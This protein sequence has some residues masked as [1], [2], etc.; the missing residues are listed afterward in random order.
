MK[1]CPK[2]GNNTFVVTAHI[3]QDWV[4]D[5]N[6][7]FTAVSSDCIEVLHKPDDDDIWQCERCGYDAPGHAF[8][9]D[10]FKML[11]VTIYKDTTGQFTD[12]EMDDPND[13]M[14]DMVE[15]LV[16]ADALWK[17]WLECLEFDREQCP[18]DEPEGGWPEATKTDM[19]RWVYEESI[20]DDAYSLYDW[21]V[22]HGYSWTKGEK[23]VR[24]A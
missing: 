5:D 18:Y 2:C 3:A 23:E 12:E 8:N 14:S 1:R 20:A 24:K 7:E 6:G 15:I 22:V 9:V 19:L 11:P 13:L 17:W 4:V 16:P 10:E 21:L